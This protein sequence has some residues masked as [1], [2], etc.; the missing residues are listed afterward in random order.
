VNVPSTLVPLKH[1]FPA[2][3]NYKVDLLPLHQFHAINSFLP[4][5]TCILRKPYYKCIYAMRQTCTFEK[6]KSCMIIRGRTWDLSWQKEF[7]VRALLWRRM[8]RGT[9]EREPDKETWALSNQKRQTMDEWT[10]K[11]PNPK[12]R[13]C[14]IIDLLTDFTALRLTDFI[15]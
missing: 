6:K 1:M 10:V 3:W 2:H 5:T 12:C 9:T 15:D 11:T 13:I 8:R 14:F 7:C 4:R